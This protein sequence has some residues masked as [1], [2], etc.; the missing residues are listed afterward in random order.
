[1]QSAPQPLSAGQRAPNIATHDV[2]LI[3]G[4][5]VQRRACQPSGNGGWCHWFWRCPVL[6]HST[7]EL[8]TLGSTMRPRLAASQEVS[9]FSNSSSAPTSFRD[10]HV[11]SGVLMTPA[12]AA[13][14]PP[15]S[16]ILRSQWESAAAHT[17]ASIGET[18]TFHAPPFCA[19][20][21]WIWRRHALD[22]LHLAGEASYMW[23]NIPAVIKQPCRL[24]VSPSKPNSVA[25]MLAA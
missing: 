10:G 15:T 1:M 23:S 19:L 12:P 21:L 7:Q 16:A 5:D 3:C 2:M 22:A 9:T 11:A 6:A 25:V 13:S 18:C 8:R 20:K 4:E 14:L 17:P 24:A